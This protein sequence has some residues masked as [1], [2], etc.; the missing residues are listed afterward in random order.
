[1]LIGTLALVA[2]ALFAGAALYINIAEQPAR[3]LLDDAALLK[4]WKPS[5]KRGFA[6]QSFLAIVSFFLGTAAWWLWGNI[7]FLVG[8][9]LMIANWPWTLI[10][11]LP[12][13]TILMAIDPS[14]GDPRI[15]P[16]LGHWNALHGVRTGLAGA[17]C[18][19]FVM[20]LVQ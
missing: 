5:Y 1:M 17:A 3:M 7:L 11:I 9:G 10:A 6:M 16:L 4:Q 2:A 19:C 12:T 20:A 15:R 14:S 8:A 18:A 13:N